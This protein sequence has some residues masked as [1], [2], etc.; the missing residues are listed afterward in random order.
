[1]HPGRD[2]GDLD[3]AAVGDRDRPDDRETEA[4]AAAGTLARGVGAPEP[5]EHL[6]LFLL[7]ESRPFVGDLDEDF[8]RRGVHRDAH[9][10][11]LRRVRERVRE[12]VREHL[13]QPRFVAEHRDRPVGGEG[14]VA[15]R[16][17]GAGVVDGVARELA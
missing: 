16:V 2:A 10:C 15:V 14:D 13:A 17:G 1:M 12:E 11:A 8:V 4:G 7:A 5:L 9:R 3:G 6:R